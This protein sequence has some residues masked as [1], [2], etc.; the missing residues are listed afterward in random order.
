MLPPIPKVNT[1]I[2][3]YAKIW[4][5]RTRGVAVLLQ[6]GSVASTL[7]T[8]GKRPKVSGVYSMA[9]WSRK[10]FEVGCVMFRKM[11]W[12]QVIPGCGLGRRC[13]RRGRHN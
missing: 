9:G 6:W 1:T 5:Q 2:L 3:K 13:R 8:L 10:M 4:V 11:G 12:L 7:Q